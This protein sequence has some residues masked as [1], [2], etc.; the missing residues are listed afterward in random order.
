[1]RASLLAPLEPI[2]AAAVRAKNAHYDRGNPQRLHWPVVSVGN[3]S[4]GGAGK[5]PLVILLA[6]LLARDG[7][8]V[9]VLSRGYGRSGGGTE[10]VDAAGDPRRFGDEP[11][12]IAQAANA[13]VFV[14]ARRYQA[15]LLA[16]RQ[17]A[18]GPRYVHLLDDGFQHRQLHRDVDIVA[19]HRDDIQGRL[20]PAGRLREPLGSLRRADILVL[21]QED[22]DLE[23]ALATYAKPGANIWRVSRQ[24]SFPGSSASAAN[25]VPAV[26]FCA[27]AHPEEFFR[28]LEAA[29]IRLAATKAFRDHH[30]YGRNDMETLLANRCGAQMFITTEKDAV[31]LDAGLRGILTADAPLRVV[32]LTLELADEPA[33]M[34]MLAAMLK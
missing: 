6:H 24:F 20:L 31:K 26:A 13:P 28:M 34:A 29:G 8:S 32:Q 3:L 27:I 10:R 11:V 2:Y 12:M 9:D 33:A 14:G 21:R 16:E 25:Q 23:D 15:G 30:R 19:I 4:V 18:A 7:F 1:M 22:S 5:T 17:P